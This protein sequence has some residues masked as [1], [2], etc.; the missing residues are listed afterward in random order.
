MQKVRTTQ[1]PG[2]G[3]LGSRYAGWTK[4]THPPCPEDGALRGGEG[5]KVNPM[6]GDILKEKI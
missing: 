1:E 6:L 5:D 3:A 2:S 4:G